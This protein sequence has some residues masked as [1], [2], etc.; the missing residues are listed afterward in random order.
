M[1]DASVDT[2]IDDR[3]VGHVPAPPV[4]FGKA[5]ADYAR[6]RQGFPP[7]FY[8]ALAAR[9][10]GLA[11]QR[12][13]DL[14]TGT[15]TVARALAARGARVTG[16]DVSAPLL[17]QAA[18]LT[19]G[20]A[21]T[22]R[23]A[24]AEDTGLAAHAHDAVTAA[25]CWHWFDRP[26]A[27]AEARRL[28][29]PGGVL[30]IAHLDWISDGGVVDDTVGLIEA[31]NGAPIPTAGLGFDGFYPR[32]P[33]EL[34]AAGFTRLE[35]AGFDHDLVYTHEAWRGR[36]RASAGVGATMPPETLARF[37]R[38]HAELLAARYPDPVPVAH[39]VFIVFAEAPR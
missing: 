35:Y 14:G 19:D 9:R 13:V 38:A 31:T 18:A 33:A 29:V 39:R 30:V 25:Q 16:V 36:I 10:V 21:V 12:I 20:G 17:A 28:L 3:P 27:A 5:A 24:A 2:S 15:G 26:R 8:D 7:R 34:R 6:H 32:W 11:G 23:R 22:W 1:R 4:D 37:D